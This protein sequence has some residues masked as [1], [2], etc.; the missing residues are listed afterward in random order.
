MENLSLLIAFGAGIASFLSPCILPLV[1]VYLANMA[2]SS[3]VVGDSAVGYRG[4]FY[5]AL[6]FVVGFSVVFI[7]LGAAAG[8]LG[9]VLSAH[10]GLLRKMAGALLIVLGLH[11]MGAIKIPF[12]YRER[13]IGLGEGRPSYWRSFL[14]G[15][16]FSLGWTP[17]IGPILGGILALAW[18]SETVWS[19]VFY[20]TAYC[21]GLGIPFLV[22]GL[23]VAPVSR[24]LKRLNR[25]LNL[26][27][28]V[29]GLFLI[30]LGALIIS[31]ALVRLYPLFDFFGITT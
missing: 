21:L 4:T 25:Y 28:I 29:S 6:L 23:A 7:A 8:W 16:A 31:E 5:H 15:L 2:G 27:S 1:P 26:V 14:V 11:L 24:Q 12:L 22:T 18:S 17:C 9:A 20:L 10:M 13:R 30:A 3:A 19:G